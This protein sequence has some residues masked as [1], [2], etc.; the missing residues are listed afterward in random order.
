MARRLT[1]SASN[2]GLGNLLRHFVPVWKKT[3]TI[4]PMMLRMPIAP[5]H[6]EK[7][8]PLA[9]EAQPQMKKP[10]PRSYRMRAR[11]TMPC[12]I[13]TFATICI[14][15]PIP[16]PILVFRLYSV[17]IVLSPYKIRH[18]L[19]NIV[20]ILILHYKGEGNS[21]NDIQSTLIVGHTPIPPYHKNNYNT[22]NR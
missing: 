20:F 13:N 10:K 8:L 15:M 14:S 19:P 9:Y 18:L 3:N 16:T 21:V 17:S 7:P 22:S 2:D 4:S 1:A 11:G 6:G 12:L 5:N